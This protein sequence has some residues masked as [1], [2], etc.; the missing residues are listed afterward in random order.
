MENYEQRRRD[1]RYR[2]QQGEADRR[3]P[4][5]WR[6]DSRRSE[7]P[8][9]AERGWLDYDREYDRDYRFDDRDR[10]HEQRYGRSSEPERARFSPD[11]SREGEE[12]RRSD[13]PYYSRN[14]ERGGSYHYGR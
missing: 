3:E 5:S 13:E 8:R 14:R 1:E 10:R 12:P 11:W 9:R 4:E 7:R 6:E 2:A